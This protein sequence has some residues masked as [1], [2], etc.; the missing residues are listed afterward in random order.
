[1][2]NERVAVNSQEFVPASG[3]RVPSITQ[4]GLHSPEQLP[5][6]ATPAYMEPRFGH[7]FSQLRV[8]PGSQPPRIFRSGE[9]PL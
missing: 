2:T 1:M 7:N 5:G 3:A 8:H 9:V 6:A 4:N